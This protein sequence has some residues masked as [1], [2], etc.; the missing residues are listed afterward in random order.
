ME[1]ISTRSGMYEL[2]KQSWSWLLRRVILPIGD[3]AFGRRMMRRL[4]FLEEAQWWDLERLRTWRDRSLRSL[5]KVAYKEVPFYRELMDSV[6]IK[7]DDIYRAEDLYKLPIVTKEMLR[8]AYPHRAIRNTGKRVY[9][10]HTSGSTGTNFYMWIDAETDGWQRSSFFLAL[11]WAGWRIGEPH[12]QTGISP[13]RSLQKRLKDIL[14]RCHYVSAFDLSDIHFDHMLEFLERHSIQH[15]WGYPGSLYFLAV[16]ARKKGW[17]VPLRTIVT[18]GDN[19][20]PHYRRTIEQAFKARV[21]DTYGCGEGMQIA[22]QCGEES[23]YHIHMLDVV[24]EYLDEE[25]CHVSPGRP[26][27][28]IITRLHPGP[29]PLIRYR[30]G[31]VGIESSNKMCECG[32]GF[33]KM[34]SIHGR[35]TDVVITPSGNRLIVHFFTGILEY[36][37]EIEAFQVLQNKPG[38]MVLRIVPTKEFSKE[39]AARIVAEIK[40][41]GAS[42]MEIEIELVTEIP[43]PPSGKRRFVTSELARRG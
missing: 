9:E 15:L 11:E 26:A 14:L 16:H 7:P 27:N 29:M 2:R 39:V 24:V 32:R 10:T 34:E 4:R 35:D 40:A 5:I 31:D 13:N 19:L 37:S 1:L 12:L 28:L 33:D 36:F 17:N 22:A 18:W 23:T 8:A 20:Y 30:V 21:F 43:L 41:K 3:R 38:I 42:D 25:A 6:G